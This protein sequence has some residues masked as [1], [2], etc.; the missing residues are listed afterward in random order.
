MDIFTSIYFYKLEKALDTVF[1]NGN[2]KLFDHVEDMCKTT[3]R[4]IT[5]QAF[6]KVVVTTK[7][8][9]ENLLLNIAFFLTTALVPSLKQKGGDR[10][11]VVQRQK[12]RGVTAHKFQKIKPQKEKRATRK[13][14]ELQLF[15]NQQESMRNNLK[16]AEKRLRQYG[17]ELSREAGPGELVHPNNSIITFNSLPKHFSKAARHRHLRRLTREGFR[18]SLTN[19]NDLFFKYYFLL[20]F[21]KVVRIVEKIQHF[22]YIRTPFLLESSPNKALLNESAA[23]ESTAN[24]NHIP[25]TVSNSTVVAL[26]NPEMAAYEL[27]SAVSGQIDYLTLPYMSSNTHQPLKSCPLSTLDTNSNLRFKR[28]DLEIVN[29]LNILSAT[30]YDVGEFSGH[31]INKNGILMFD[32]RL[33]VGKRASVSVSRYWEVDKNIVAK[34]HMHPHSFDRMESPPSFADVIVT[35]THTLLDIVPYHFVFTHKGIYIIKFQ[36]NFI[37][38]LFTWVQD[39]SVEGYDRQEYFNTVNDELEKIRDTYEK[40]GHIYCFNQQ[41][42]HLNFANNLMTV[43]NPNNLEETMVTGIDILFVSNKDLLDGKMPPLPLAAQ[44]QDIR[45]KVPRS[46]LLN[47]AEGKHIKEQLVPVPQ[48]NGLSGTQLIAA[49]VDMYDPKNTEIATFLRSTTQ[50]NEHD[51]SRMWRRIK[52]NPTLENEYH[53]VIFKNYTRIMTYIIRTD[54]EISQLM[55]NKNS[56]EKLRILQTPEVLEIMEREII[57][58]IRRPGYLN[59]VNRLRGYLALP[60]GEPRPTATPI[61]TPMPVPTQNPIILT[62]MSEPPIKQTSI[63]EKVIVTLLMGGAASFFIGGTQS[64]VQHKRPHKSILDTPGLISKM[65]LGSKVTETVFMDLPYPLN[66]L[67]K[68]I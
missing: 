23:D 27:A 64:I 1:F 26:L 10:Q 14:Q 29:S 32:G 18:T 33:Q 61:P 16:N 2:P 55:A 17:K 40:N 66:I 25:S 65:I 47:L 49:F 58:F 7:E 60:S 8:D 62:P 52:M 21:V 37:N 43:P 50:E 42:G 24:K 56:K 44:A 54:T 9:Y 15:H 59:D 13:R 4:V 57:K 34:F 31:I 6:S 48:L 51:F 45:S 12:Q 22:T 5:S 28:E 63:L 46:Y 41:S 36:D 20:F 38:A 35:L 30:I 67:K 53:A 68:Y 3:K 39:K 19:N 11:I